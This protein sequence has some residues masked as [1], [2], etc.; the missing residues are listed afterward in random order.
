MGRK[1]VPGV[2][3]IDEAWVKK[4]IKL[5]LEPYE[6]LHTWMPPAGM[7]GNNGQHDFLNCQIG[8]FWTIEAKAGDNGPTAGQ[9]KFAREIQNAGGFCLCVNEFNLRHVKRLA[10]YINKNNSLPQVPHM[11]HE[12]NHDFE[13]WTPKKY[14]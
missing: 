11:H 14:T 4:E 3:E 12:L 13:A 2:D 10:D 9:I 7:W 1:L 6:W 5:I 8:L